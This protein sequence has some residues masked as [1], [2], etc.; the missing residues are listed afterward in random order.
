MP[1]DNKEATEAELMQS[2]TEALSPHIDSFNW[3]ATVGLDKLSQ[4]FKKFYYRDYPIPGLGYTLRVYFDNLKLKKPRDDAGLFRSNIDDTVSSGTTGKLLP[5]VCRRTLTTYQGELSGDLHFDLINYKP[6]PETNLRKEQAVFNVSIPYENIFEVPIM[7]KSK[8]CHLNGIMDSNKL[9]QLG[10]EPYEAGGYFI[11]NG[12]EKI[13]RLTVV[14]KRNL[15]FSHIQPN[16]G[17]TQIHIRSVR[18]DEFS[19]DVYISYDA[20]T[21]FGVAASSEVV[22]ILP[23]VLILKC[24]KPYVTDQKIFDLLTARCDDEATKDK[25]RHSLHE[26]HV[27]NANSQLEALQ[28]FGKIVKPLIYRARRY[29]SDEL[30]RANLDIP[31]EILGKQFLDNN[32]FVHLESF[33]EKFDFLVLCAQKLIGGLSGEF[34]GENRDSF[35]IAEPLTSGA[36]IL[37]M[38]HGALHMRLSMIVSSY[39]KQNRSWKR[40]N[41]V[42]SFPG[43]IKQVIEFCRKVPFKTMRSLFSTGAFPVNFNGFRIVLEHTTGLIVNA[44]RLNY[45]RFLSHFRSLHKGPKFMDSR[46]LHVRKLFPD[47]FGFVCPVHTPDGGPCGLLNHLS[48]TCQIHFDS[49]GEDAQKSEEIAAENKK[50]MIS[51]LT[52]LGMIGKISESFLSK[53]LAPVLIDGAIVG[54]VPVEDVNEF[55]NVLRL[56]KVEENGGFQK[57]HE[58]IGFP[59]QGNNQSCQKWYPQIVINTTNSRFMRPVCHM[60][61]NKVELISPLEQEFMNIAI[62]D[63]DLQKHPNPNVTISNE[64]KQKVNGGIVMQENGTNFCSVA[65]HREVEPTVFLSNVASLTPFSDFNQSPRNVYQCQMGK[66]TMGTPAFAW[67]NRKDNK[68]YRITTPQKPM[69]QTKHQGHSLPFNEY[70]TGTNAVVAV[71]SYTGYDMEDAMILNKSTFERGF[72]HGCVYKTKTYDLEDLFPAAED[73]KTPRYFDNV[74]KPEEKEGF[75]HEQY[76]GYVEENGLPTVGRIVRPHDPL[77]IGYSEKE[78]QHRVQFYKLDESAVIDSV[79]V[80]PN[81]ETHVVD[82]CIVTFRMKRNPIIGDKF[83]SRHGQKGVCSV[84]WPQEDFPF[85]ESGIVPDVIINPHAFPSRMTIGMLIETMASK[86]GAIHG[87]FPDA[88]PFTFNEKETAV[89]YF[90]QQLKKAGYNYYGNETMYSGSLGVEMKAEIFIGLCYYQRLRHMVSDKFQCRVSGRIDAL[91]HQPVKGRKKG[92]GVRFGEMERDALLGYGAS[93]LVRDRLFINSDHDWSHVCKTC[94]TF[95]GIECAPNGKDL[96]CKICG[97]SDN[98]GIVPMPYV[99]KY[100]VNELAAMNIKTTLHF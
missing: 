1:A 36:V 61:A 17:S 54:A 56:L 44:E 21:G 35:G 10:E 14:T 76:E 96:S 53:T 98:I 45:F 11:T 71:L 84:L 30:E 16:T 15:P 34:A 82:K 48:R 59:Y 33:E 62:L 28:S 40:K 5:A 7:V 39:K 52:S 3:A 4:N 20:V 46:I 92:G 43:D 95:L 29:D 41:L 63:E 18:N 50:K 47:Q 66:Q 23:L 57:Y 67:P 75:D 6:D 27:F 83:S 38:I 81:P 90:G 51:S 91:T 19:K 86:S 65:T 69:A 24:L 12:T 68:M 77:F 2:C 70:L 79:T 94:G 80:L 85:T 31:S 26:A 55:T 32:M 87:F 58:I 8:L 93:Y 100:M 49:T 73:G 9:I 99:T 72:A 60:A 78:Q 37:N 88:T 42:Q 89:D 25:I 13:A 97:S 64:K 74:L 22:S